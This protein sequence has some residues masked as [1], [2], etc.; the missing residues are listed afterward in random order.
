MAY[1]IEHASPAKSEP[2]G[3]SVLEFKNNKITGPQKTLQSFV[4]AILSEGGPLSTDKTA[5]SF[6]TQIKNNTLR[7]KSDI[8]NVFVLLRPSLLIA[9]NDASRP[10]NEVIS[11]IEITEVNVSSVDGL[12]ITFE[13]TFLSGANTTFVVPVKL[14]V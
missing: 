6:I 7:S 12:S 10:D 2:S 8:S 14:N 11:E 4:V 13:V 9:I 3:R 5:A 1:D